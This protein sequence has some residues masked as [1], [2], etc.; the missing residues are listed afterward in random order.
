MAHCGFAI[1]LR[2]G[3]GH[4]RV[5]LEKAGPDDRYGDIMVDT[6]RSHGAYR[7]WMERT[8]LV[9]GPDGLRRPLWF[10]RPVRPSLS[11]SKLERP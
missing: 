11:S 6:E 5:R 8:R 2:N 1:D 4:Q 9:S 3:V 10:G 7:E